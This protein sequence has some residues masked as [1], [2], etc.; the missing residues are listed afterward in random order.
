MCA[1]G[2]AALLADVSPSSISIS[3][4]TAAAPDDIFNNA[5]CKSFSS[6]LEQCVPRKQITVSVSGKDDDPTL[7]HQGIQ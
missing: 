2:G 1:L 3:E 5:L 7:A 4:K 6:D